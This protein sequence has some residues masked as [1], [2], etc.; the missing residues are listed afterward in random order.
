MG[1]GGW[2]WT[3]CT[4][5][6]RFA[7]ATSY[8]LRALAA[9]LQARKQKALE[10]RRAAE[11][12]KAL[13]QEDGKGEEADDRKENGRKEAFLNEKSG[14]MVTEDDGEEAK[15]PDVEEDVV[16]ET[17]L[18]LE[19][20]DISKALISRSHYA[21]ITKP[22]S[23]LEH[24]L[25]RRLK[26]AE[27]EQKQKV[28]FEQLVQHYRSEQG[29]KAKQMEEEAVCNNV[30]SVAEVTLPP[31]KTFTSSGSGSSG[32]G[33]YQ[34]YSAT[35]RGAGHDS[36]SCY[37][38]LCR[39]LGVRSSTKQNLV[40]ALP[41]LDLTNGDLDEAGSEED[42]SNNNE[43]SLETEDKED[44]ISGQMNEDSSDSTK[45]KNRIL[46]ETEKQILAKSQKLNA[47]DQSKKTEAHPLSS[48]PSGKPGVLASDGDI[49]L[50][51]LSSFLQNGKLQLTPDLITQLEVRLA[52]MGR[53]E[54]PVHLT[55]RGPGRPAK[56]APGTKAAGL[57]KKGAIPSV[58][59]FLT[60]S[61]K[62]SL[63]V[64]RRH[65]LRSLARHEGKRETPGFNYACK[66]NNVNWPYPCP[67]PYFKTAW[68]YRT[69]TMQNLP[70]VAVQLR[71]LW[72]CLRWDDL[73]AK[74][75]ASGTNTVTTDA[76]ITTTKILKRRDVGPYGLR[77]EFLVR[78]IVIP[79][80]VPSQPRGKYISCIIFYLVFVFVVP[81]HNA[82]LLF[83]CKALKCTCLDCT[84]Q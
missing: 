8:G 57:L 6:T 37:S 27:L 30:D 31:A 74:P 29:K 33:K 64:L 70:A 79:I 76:D 41:N 55:K 60:P 50:V 44:G 20:F 49:A 34:C 4:R 22:Y 26:Q 66:M 83:A 75:P 24:L 82:L 84:M 46:N 42:G 16:P 80:S 36:K 18:V 15:E 38:V 39:E 58:H 51:S 62:S 2:I 48:E 12:G 54:L 59:R 13:D 23:R 14:L 5:N 40:D 21:R 78:K 47:Q 17:K 11:E 9:K 43:V 56:S 35:C 3:S 67:R 53:T 1:Q 77:S 63:F 71:I 52:R 7:P 25:D 65:F 28:L 81:F 45:L 72:A 73:A 68:E 69:Q 10:K 19:N 32:V 61:K